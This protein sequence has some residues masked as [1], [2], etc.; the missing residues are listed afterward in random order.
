MNPRRGSLGPAAAK[1]KKGPMDDAAPPPAKMKLP[2]LHVV[3]GSSPRGSVGDAALTTVFKSDYMLLQH[4]CDKLERL[5][6]IKAGVKTSCESEFKS[7]LTNCAQ[8]ETIMAREKYASLEEAVC[9]LSVKIGLNELVDRK[10]QAMEKLL[11]QNTILDSSPEHY[12]TQTATLSRLPTFIAVIDRMVQLQSVANQADTPRDPANSNATGPPPATN[13]PEQPKPI[14]HD[15][16]TAMVAE[17]QTAQAI[18]AALRAHVHHLQAQVT[19]LEAKTADGEAKH[20]LETERWRREI[21]VLKTECTTQ[22]HT[23]TDLTDRLHASQRALVNASHEVETATCQVKLLQQE[24]HR[25][26]DVVRYLQDEKDAAVDKV[27]QL[28]CHASSVSLQLCEKEASVLLWKTELETMKQRL[29]A[30]IDAMHSDVKAA[31][32]GQEAA[33]A[34]AL[35]DAE[36][37]I[38]QLVETSDG[39]ATLVGTVT[40]EDDALVARIEASLDCLQTNDPHAFDLSIDGITTLKVGRSLQLAFQLFGERWRDQAQDAAVNSS[41]LHI[42]LEQLEHKL[43]HKQRELAD[44]RV[45]LIVMEGLATERL[46][47]IEQLRVQLEEGSVQRS[48]KE[49]ALQQ[50]I[51]SLNQE[52]TC[53]LESIEQLKK[54]KREIIH[55]QCNESEVLVMDS[56]E[57]VLKQEFAVMKKAFELKAKQAMDQLETQE[58]AH[59]KQMQDLIR[60]H[61]EDRMA[62]EMKAKK[63]Q[64]DLTTLRDKVKGLEEGALQ[65]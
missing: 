48:M 52:I 37:Q 33:H 65:E 9:M 17:L 3:K 8:A 58:K 47:T 2:V 44:V 24:C 4:K 14:E 35:A 25:H 43:A 23:I 59:F 61:K 57:E 40:E 27:Q 29:Q 22:N 31:T 16:A 26:D 56:Y 50:S 64:H 13:Q 18:T 19:Q 5:W 62:E 1:P 53:H 15:R 55:D 11:L 32:H 45:V 28:E 10:M 12:V 41:A 36:T 49:S 42:E 21:E 7:V 46:D 34:A 51:T 39:L 60:K 63:M 54:E 30:Q 20:R 38:A 6:G